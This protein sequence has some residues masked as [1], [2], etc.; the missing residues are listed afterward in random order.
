MLRIAEPSDI[1]PIFN[2]SCDALDEK[3]EPFS[4]SHLMESIAE[5][6][7]RKNVCLSTRDGDIS[8]FLIWSE[9]V[10][11]LTGKPIFRKIAFYVSPRHRGGSS[12]LKLM[13]FAIERAKMIGANKLIFSAII[14]SDCIRVSSLYQKLG[15]T[16]TEITH[17]MRF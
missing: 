8:G 4:S 1:D 13:L 9:S 14:D 3:G 7:S 11:T 10:H 12:A 15:L 2:L 5:A 17:E 16:P 6:I